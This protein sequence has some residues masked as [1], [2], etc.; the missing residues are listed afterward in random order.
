MLNKIQIKDVS[1]CLD[2]NL[3]PIEISNGFYSLLGG[4]TLMRVENIENSIFGVKGTFGNSIEYKTSSNELSS[5]LF[6]TF[7]ERGVCLDFE[8]NDTGLFLKDIPGTRIIIE[9]DKNFFVKDISYLFVLKDKITGNKIEGINAQTRL[10][11]GMYLLDVIAVPR[12]GK[13]RCLGIEQ[14]PNLFSPLFKKNQLI[15][16]YAIENLGFTSDESSTILNQMIK[17]LERA[18]IEFRLSIMDTV[19]MNKIKS[20]S[21]SYIEEISGM[22][23]RY[24]ILHPGSKKDKIGILYLVFD[25]NGRILGEI[26]YGQEGLEYIPQ[27]GLKVIPVIYESGVDVKGSRIESK[28]SSTEILLTN[29]SEY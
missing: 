13:R 2:I 1:P 26:G 15:R 22:K 8:L 7:E 18:G 17:T 21:R 24:L 25:E 4:G 14:I 9:D 29:S 28:T 19:E 27:E 23:E 20:K 6:K 11:N 5:I 10:K 16:A 3:N 12:F